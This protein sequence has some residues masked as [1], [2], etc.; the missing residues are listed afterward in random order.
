MNNKIYL[1]KYDNCE[2]YEDHWVSTLCGCLNKEEASKLTIEL[3][4][5]I[6]SARANKPANYF[7]S[8]AYKNGITANVEEIESYDAIERDYLAA[9]KP[10][11]GFDVILDAIDEFGYKRGY[12]KMEEVELFSN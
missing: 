12:V 6:K 5:W 8:E 4:E 1:V 3:N 9:L 10:P 7:N 2:A 11:Y